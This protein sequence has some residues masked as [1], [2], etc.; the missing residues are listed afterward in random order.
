MQAR[1][2]LFP[3]EED[4]LSANAFPI[5]DLLRAEWE[6]VQHTHGL[7]GSLFNS[8]AYLRGNQLKVWPPMDGQPALCIYRGWML[9]PQQY[10][11]LHNDLMAFNLQLIH[12]PEQYERFHLFPNVYPLLQSATPKTIWFEN[13]DEVDPAKIKA[14]FSRFMIKDYVKSVKGSPF[15]TFFT[16]DIS[17]AELL[18]RVHE[19]IDL[20]STLFTGGLVFKEFVDLKFYDGA[21]NEYR[22]FYLNGSLLSL[23]RNAN[24]YSTCPAPPQQMIERFASLPGRF[25]T[26][27]F[28]ELSD[29]TWIVIEAGDGQV[30]G[31]SP[32][33]NVN[34]FFE[35]IS[36]RQDLA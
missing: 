20:R 36:F 4:K 2:I 15:P 32:G 34:R 11:A 25:Y 22:A 8:G 30:S 28:A 5:D 7:R 35:E 1:L 3:S 29:G 27:D 21:P 23:S 31:L 16:N 33:Q 13:A 9:K 14:T 17:D 24:Q 6:A 18:Q 19:F 12:S 10:R 26:V